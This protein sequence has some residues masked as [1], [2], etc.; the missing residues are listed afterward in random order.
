VEKLLVKKKKSVIITNSDAP[1]D[2]V[3]SDV[4]P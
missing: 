2:T 3:F 1:E 4:T